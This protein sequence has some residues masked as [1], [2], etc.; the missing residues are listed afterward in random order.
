MDSEDVL[1]FLAGYGVGSMLVDLIK[2]I[3]SIYKEK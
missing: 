3:I 1:Y 2:L